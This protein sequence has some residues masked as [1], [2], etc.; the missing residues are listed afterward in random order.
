MHLKSYKMVIRETLSEIKPIPKVE[1][2]CVGHREQS[3]PKLPE[4]KY[5]E[6]RIENKLHSRLFT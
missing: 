2:V 1:N 3:L 6:I 4:C 5:L